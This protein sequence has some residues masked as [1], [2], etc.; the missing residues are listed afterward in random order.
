MTLVP[1]SVVSA[2]LACPRR[3]E[4]VDRRLAHGLDPTSRWIRSCRLRR[5]LNGAPT[6]RASRGGGGALPC[7]TIA[8]SRSSAGGLH[9]MASHRESARDGRESA[10]S[11]I[12]D[13]ESNGATPI[14]VPAGASHFHRASSSSHN[15]NSSSLVP[16]DQTSARATHDGRDRGKRGEGACWMAARPP[17][18][19]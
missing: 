18:A 3:M 19:S 16:H 15:F 4:R 8:P 14:E 12:V 7:S 10:A 17:R 13:S 11:S 1:P 9:L 5:R 6:A 2:C